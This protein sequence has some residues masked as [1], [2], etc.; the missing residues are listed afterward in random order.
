MGL[1]AGRKR[2]R[3]GR[4]KPRSAKFL[5]SFAL[6]TKLGIA[7]FQVENR[8]P[9]AQSR[10]PIDVRDRRGDQSLAGAHEGRASL[11]AQISRQP[12]WL[13]KRLSPLA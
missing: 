6:G 12:M 7:R 4:T 5:L 8:V 1:S 13:K 10:L 3:R 2:E 9:V 11:L